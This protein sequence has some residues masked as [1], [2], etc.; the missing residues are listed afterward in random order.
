MGPSST[1]ESL[2]PPLPPQADIATKLT[3]IKNRITIFII[4]FVFI[5]PVEFLRPFLL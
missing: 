5:S 4:I 2:P 3:P 1:T